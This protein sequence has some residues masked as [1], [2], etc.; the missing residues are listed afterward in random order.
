MS[1]TT[2]RNN[3]TRYAKG[4]Q[5]RADNEKYKFNRDPTKPVFEVFL[6]F[7][8]EQNKIRRDLNCILGGAAAKDKKKKEIVAINSQTSA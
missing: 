5:D 3:H 8:S 6:D 1:I 2:A 4:M 7:L